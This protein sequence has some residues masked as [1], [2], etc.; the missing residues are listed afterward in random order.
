MRQIKNVNLWRK[1]PRVTY[2]VS[3]TSGRFRQIDMMKNLKIAI[4]K[5]LLTL[6]IAKKA[7]V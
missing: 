3:G 7:K 1:R 6:K 4:D 2:T 5:Q